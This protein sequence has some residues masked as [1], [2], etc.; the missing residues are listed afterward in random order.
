MWHLCNSPQRGA[1]ALQG[2]SLNAGPEQ[3]HKRAFPAVVGERSTARAVQHLGIGRDG[4]ADCVHVLERALGPVLLD[5]NFPPNSATQD[6]TQL[7]EADL[8]LLP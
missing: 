3:K 1:A 6:R 4:V 5:K 2:E 8:A 7:T